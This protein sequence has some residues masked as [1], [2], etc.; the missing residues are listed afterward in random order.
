MPKYVVCNN[1]RKH[2]EL[3]EALKNRGIEFETTHCDNKCFKCRTSVMIKEDDKYISATS[4]EK[5]LRKINIS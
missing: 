1:T 3:V 5:L 2:D 4:V